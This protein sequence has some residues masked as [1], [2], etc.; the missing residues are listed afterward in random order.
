MRSLEA[1]GF[2]GKGGLR[3]AEEND[4]KFIRSAFCDLVGY[5]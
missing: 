3:F 1:S 2:T 4:V 5:D